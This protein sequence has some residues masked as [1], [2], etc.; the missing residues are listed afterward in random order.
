MEESSDHSL[1]SNP[2]LVEPTSADDGMMREVLGGVV[3]VDVKRDVL[4]AQQQ[5]L[6][7]QGT[8]ISAYK[9][10]IVIEDTNGLPHILGS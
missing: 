6:E 2:V 9:S 4:G 1:R 10:N 5:R 3:D 8:V 7:S